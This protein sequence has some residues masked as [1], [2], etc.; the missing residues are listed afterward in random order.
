MRQ[1]MRMRDTEPMT[2]KQFTITIDIASESTHEAE[3]IFD[4]V[5]LLLADDFGGEAEA[6]F[7]SPDE[8]IDGDEF[9]AAIPTRDLKLTNE[10]MARLIDAILTG[11]GTTPE[12]D[13][14]TDTPYSF[15]VSFV[16]SRPI[17]E[18]EIKGLEAAIAA[19]VEEPAIHDADGHLV[20]AEYSTSHVVVGVER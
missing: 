7:G 9:V 8:L 15:R 2:K 13:E 5:Q 16:A 3:D 20:D 10:Q 1:R 18:E 19:Q 11:K 17:T 6:S 4:A 12:D 14:I